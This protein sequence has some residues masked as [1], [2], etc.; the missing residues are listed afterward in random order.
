LEGNA[1]NFPGNLNSKLLLAV[2]A[3]KKYGLP[4]RYNNACDGH[5]TEWPNDSGVPLS[6]IDSRDGHSDLD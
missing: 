3:F 6:L 1:P 2:F 4:F 5:A